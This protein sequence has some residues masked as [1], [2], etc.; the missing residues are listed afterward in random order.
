MAA[1]LRTTSS[2]AF[3]WIKIYISTKISLEFF[4]KGPISKSP[5]LVQAPAR[6]QAI[7][8]TNDGQFTVAYMRHSAS[9]I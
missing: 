8:W 7:V 1:I 6:R 3:S 2:N 5:A 4:P 9:V